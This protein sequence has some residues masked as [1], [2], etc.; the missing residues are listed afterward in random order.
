MGKLGMMDRLR[1]RRVRAGLA[2]SAL[3]LAAAASASAQTPAPSGP[4]GRWVGTGLQ[5]DWLGRP[6]E[7]PRIEVVFDGADD[8][9]ID[10]PTLGCSGVLTRIGG[11][12][13]LVEYRETLTTGLDKC[14]SGA[15]VAR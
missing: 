11:V 7:I 10:Y 1:V 9:T 14:P 5:V 8:G 15:T 12:G 6:L 3:A 2:V 4:I 13:N